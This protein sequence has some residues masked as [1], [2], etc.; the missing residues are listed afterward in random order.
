MTFINIKHTCVIWVYSFKLLYN[1]KWRRI[2]IFMELTVY[3]ICMHMRMTF[4]FLFWTFLWQ[5]WPTRLVIFLNRL[6][7]AF[8]LHGFSLLTLRVYIYI[9]GKNIFLL[10]LFH[11][12]LP[13]YCG[14]MWIR[15]L[16]NITFSIVDRNKRFF[17]ITEH[18][19][20]FQGKSFHCLFNI[21]RTRT[22]I[23]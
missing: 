3:H 16:N 1:S 2:Y 15:I 18:K 14:G 23:R 8:G 21:H 6:F 4:I 13:P 12:K 19:N 9:A 11:I 17:W 7:Y 22:L 5:N 20:H 10:L